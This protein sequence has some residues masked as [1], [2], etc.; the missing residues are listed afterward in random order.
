MCRVG[1]AAQLPT[2]RVAAGAGKDAASERDAVAWQRSARADEPQSRARSEQR[3]CVGDPA[4]ARAGVVAAPAR[5]RV[6]ASVDDEVGAAGTNT[7][8]DLINFYI[9][10]LSLTIFSR[11][12]D[13]SQSTLLFY[14]V[15]P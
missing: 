10:Y 8:W 11:E 9:S 3:R 6:E 5:G 14:Q 12:I 13:L 15:E 7:V 2:L 1:R 4:L